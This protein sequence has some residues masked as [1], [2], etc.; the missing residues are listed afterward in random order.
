MTRVQRWSLCLALAALTGISHAAIPISGTTHYMADFDDLFMPSSP[1]NVPSDTPWADNSTIPGWWF[2][3]TGNAPGAGSFGGNSFAYTGSDGAFI[4][5]YTLNSMGS[6]GSPD[7]AF[8]TPATTARGEQSGIVVFQN[9]S[10]QPVE[11]T[12]ISYDGEVRRTGSPSAVESVF[13]WYRKAATEAAALT[14]TTEPVNSTVFPPEVASGPNSYYVTGWNEL[15]EARFTYSNPLGG[16]QVDEST[17]V[18]ATLS[19]PLRM[20][21][22]EFLAVR[23]SNI[24]DL[25]LDALLGIDDLDMSF[26]AL[27]AGVSAIVSNVVRDDNGTPR[28]SIDDTIDFTLNVLGTG[29]VSPAGWVIAAPSAFANSGLYGTPK[30]F[31]GVPI[32]EFSAPDHAAGFTVRDAANSALAGTGVVVAPWCSITAAVPGSFYLDGGTPVDGADDMAGPTVMADGLF[33]GPSYSVNPATGL[34]YGVPVAGPSFTPGSYQTL[35]FTDDVDPLCTASMP[36]ITPSIIGVNATNVTERAILSQL[37]TAGDNFNG[38]A[39]AWQA[40]PAVRSLLMNIGG[41]NSRTVRSE[42]V[43]LSAV[44]GAVKFTMELAVRDT[45]SGFEVNDVFNAELILTGPGGSTV[46]LIP[47][48]RIGGSPSDTDGDGTLAGIEIASSGAFSGIHTLSFFIPD[49]ITSIQ[50]V[51]RGVNNSLSEFM[52]VQNMRLAPPEVE[53]TAPPQ[54]FVRGAGLSLKIPIA[55]ILAA[56]SAPPCAVLSFTSAGP[57]N[58]GAVIQQTATHLIYIPANDN[59]DSFSYTV[60]GGGNSRAGN[61]ISIMISPQEGLVL[62][63]TVLPGGGY[64]GNFAGIPG[65]TYQILQSSNLSKWNLLQT[66]TA[67]A[68]GLFSF[69]DPVSRPRSCYRLFYQP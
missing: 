42:I 33:T 69:T 36:V 19:S 49:A 31:T 57:G 55:D 3:Y 6:A 21:P 63:G 2:Y 65:F 10:G 25:A 60:S 23:F 46:N 39:A 5:I 26:V 28:N 44:C 32:S 24:N 37:D 47:T 15:P 68:N 54:L 58:Q 51:I 17:P 22:G 30:A 8:A 67:P 41:L 52:T 11:L 27:N 40:D 48:A 13:V 1:S 38:P 35:V 7:R 62:D 59:P 61:T 64:T 50:V 14:M 34:T 56:C 4:P 43:D 29:P 9:T 18:N 66:I 45:S 12:N 16:T 20:N 53:I